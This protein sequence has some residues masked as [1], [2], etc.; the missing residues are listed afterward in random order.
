MYGQSMNSSKPGLPGNLISDVGPTQPPLS[1][2]MKTMQFAVWTI[3]PLL[4][5]SLQAQTPFV[6]SLAE[7]IESFLQKTFS[8]S[9]AGMVTGI[10]DEHG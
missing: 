4:G 10:I 8:D 1:M 3:V 5:S 2:K 9:N 7:A 6:D